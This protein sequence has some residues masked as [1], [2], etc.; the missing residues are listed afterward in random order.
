MIEQLKRMYT[1]QAFCLLLLGALMILPVT[2]SANTVGKIQKVSVEDADED[3]IGLYW[4]EVQYADYYEVQYSKKPNEGFLTKKAEGYYFDQYNP[5]Y[6][7]GLAAGTV[8]YVRVRAVNEDVDSGKK[9]YGTFSDVLKTATCP[10][11]R[12]S[13][14]KQTKATDTSVTI[15]WDPVPAATG[16]RIVIDHRRTVDVT[17]TTVTLI[18]LENYSSYELM[19]YPYML[20]DG[21]NIGVN[22]DEYS[23]SDIYVDDRDERSVITVYTNPPAPKKINA[24]GDYKSCSASITWSANEYHLPLEYRLYNEKGKKIKQKK[25]YDNSSMAI[26]ELYNLGRNK[27]YGFDVRYAMKENGKTYYSKWSD[28]VY[29]A[30]A[31]YKTSIKWKKKTKATVTWKKVKG[32]GRYTVYISKAYGGGYKKVG[33]TKKNKITIKKFGKK[34]ISY[35]QGYWV[36]IKAYKKVGKKWRLACESDPAEMSYY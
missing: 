16:Y 30:C 19:I 36:V 22:E 17:K 11:K 21:K 14:L 8:Y 27:V 34:K 23:D 5:Y 4:N 31:N 13:G 28:K 24:Y 29:F 32:V 7:N 10:K 15:K 1:L 20:L 35:K 9:S 33:T 25:F 18:Q 3:Y 6:L 26:I 2:I 12:V